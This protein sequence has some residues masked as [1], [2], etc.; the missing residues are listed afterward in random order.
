M[1][2]DYKKPLGQGFDEFLDDQFDYKNIVDKITINANEWV[3][4]NVPIISSWLLFQNPYSGHGYDKPEAKV[5]NVGTNQP[6]CYK[7]YIPADFPDINKAWDNIWPL[8]IEY[9]M[10]AKLA[11]ERV[12]DKLNNGTQKGKNIVVYMGVEETY[13]P[14]EWKEFFHRL[15]DAIPPDVHMLPTPEGT[16]KIKDSFISIRRERGDNGKYGYENSNIPENSVF[17]KLI[18]HSPGNILNLGK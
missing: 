5:E 18:E 9:G 13:T 4:L 1:I 10:N 14:E 17:Y 12:I 11:T 15:T 3:V 7:L 16:F 6:N 2:I 8:I